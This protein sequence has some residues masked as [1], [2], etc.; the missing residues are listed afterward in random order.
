MWVIFSN[1]KQSALRKLKL[2]PKLNDIRWFN[3]D[4]SM[5][6][7]I[8]PVYLTLPCNRRLSHDRSVRLSGLHF[9]TELFIVRK[10]NAVIS[11][12]FIFR[13][14]AKL[15]MSTDPPA[16]ELR[17]DKSRASTNSPLVTHACLDTANTFMCTN[18][19]SSYP[20]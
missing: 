7:W 18:Q 5:G 13:C 6:F 1:T 10:N 12:S 17:I 15:L 11:V 9:R 16:F 4:K 20:I 19:C 2:K 8:S 14:S 3:W